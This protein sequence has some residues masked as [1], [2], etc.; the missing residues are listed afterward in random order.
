MVQYRR[1]ILGSFRAF[2]KRANTR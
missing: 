2:N 1:L